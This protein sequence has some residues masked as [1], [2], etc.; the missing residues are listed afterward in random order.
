MLQSDTIELN[1]PFDY[2]RDS[3]EKF[4]KMEKIWGH[5]KNGRDRKFLHTAIMNS[6]GRGVWKNMGEIGGNVGFWSGNCRIFQKV[7]DI[8][9]VR[10]FQNNKP[11]SRLYFFVPQELYQMG[12]FSDETDGVR[13]PNGHRSGPSGSNLCTNGIAQ[14]AGKIN[15][16]HITPRTYRGKNKLGGGTTPDFAYSP[17]FAISRIKIVTIPTFILKEA[18]FGKFTTAFQNKCSAAD[19]I[20]SHK[21]NVDFSNAK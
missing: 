3:H 12:R 18:R 5:Q 13:G 11:Y 7:R 20:L 17:W 14:T 6:V 1:S 4:S 15:I 8:E 2:Q 21:G 16:T 9:G 19:D 10:K